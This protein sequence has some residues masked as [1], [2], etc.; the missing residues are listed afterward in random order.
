MSHFTEDNTAQIPALQMLM[1]F[2]LTN[3]NRESKSFQIITQND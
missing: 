2:Y 1:K 3:I